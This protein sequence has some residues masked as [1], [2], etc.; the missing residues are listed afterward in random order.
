MNERK[1]KELNKNQKSRSQQKNKK[2]KEQEIY[3]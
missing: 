3:N 2:L 1:I